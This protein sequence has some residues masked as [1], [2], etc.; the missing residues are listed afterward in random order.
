MGSSRAASIG[1]TFPNVL[2]TTCKS[3][4]GDTYSF[5]GD[6]LRSAEEETSVLLLPNQGSLGGW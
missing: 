2:W 1:G 3:L 6:V 4:F 5:Y